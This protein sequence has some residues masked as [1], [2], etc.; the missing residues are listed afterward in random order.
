MTKYFRKLC[1]KKIDSKISTLVD[2][3]VVE[4]ETIY[5]LLSYLCYV[6]CRVTVCFII[7]VNGVFDGIY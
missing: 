3:L 5:T 2:S 1:N 4:S 7:Y 6:Q